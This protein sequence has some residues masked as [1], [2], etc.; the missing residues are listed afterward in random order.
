MKNFV[1]DLW[2]DLREKKLW[3]VAVVLLLGLVAVPVMLKKDAEVAPPPQT[4]AADATTPA[5]L[6]KAAVTAEEDP[7]PDS[8]LGVFDARNPFKKAPRPESAVAPSSPGTSTGAGAS[9]PPAEKPG[10]GAP[11][12]G[13]GGG[14]PGTGSPS[15]SPN[16]GGEKK[17]DTSYTYTVDV[18]FGRRGSERRHNLERLEFLPNSR[19]PLVVYMGVSTDRKSAVFLIDTSLEQTG[20][21]GCKPSVNVCS[22]VYLSL[23][24][25]QDEHF[26]ADKETGREYKL[27]LLKINKVSTKALAARKH[28]MRKSNM[29]RAVRLKKK[30]PRPFS[31]L[32]LLVDEQG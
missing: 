1:L 30:T 11:T 31:F 21:G 32:P 17:D 24:D 5:A 10:G 16:N 19:Q 8:D 9:A 4:P 26:F 6:A 23:E 20:E 7:S 2:Y 27:Q 3:P 15:P 18:K 22:F 29:A 13:G 14:Q 25:D 28:R 12:G